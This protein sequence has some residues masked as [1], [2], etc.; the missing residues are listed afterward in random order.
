MR[1]LILAAAL[2]GIFAVSAFAGGGDVPIAVKTKFASEY[3]TVKKAKWDNEDG[4][5]EASFELNGVEM[6]ATY[7]A[8][9]NK[10]ETESEIAVSALPK[11]A[12][13]YVSKNLAGKKIKESSKIVDS[14]NTTTFEAEVD[15][16]DY[17]FDSNGN[18]LS[19]KVEN[20]EDKDDDEKDEKK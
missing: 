6:S 7:D 10:L 8:S 13:E 15:G 16:A 11:A 2:L 4:K 9:A 19:K 14:K 12:V 1:K 3:P 18:F 17:I 5:F 20:D